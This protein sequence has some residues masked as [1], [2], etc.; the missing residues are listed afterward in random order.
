MVCI[1]LGKLVGVTMSKFDWESFPTY[2]I[3]CKKLTA[4][5]ELCSIFKQHNIKKYV[6]SFVYD[7]AVTV[8][9][10]MSSPRSPSQIWGERV[11]RQLAHAFSWGPKRIDG[12]SGADWVIIER[13]FKLKYGVELDHNKL[14]LVVWDVS[15]YD[16]QSFNHFKEVESMESEKIDQHIRLLG[17]KPIGNIN[18]EANKR[19]RKFVSVDAY[20][21]IFTVE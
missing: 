19:N 10:G 8:K 9:I 4:P 18:D 11:Y 1:S 5:S 2:Y 21:S 7:N 12:S 15:N 14:M 3:L 13:D 20:N 6:Y 16:F 17:E